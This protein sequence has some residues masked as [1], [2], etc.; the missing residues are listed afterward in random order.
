VV[1]LNCGRVYFDGVEPDARGYPCEDG[2]HLKTVVGIEEALLMGRVVITADHDR[3]ID[4][5]SDD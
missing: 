4:C 2:C 5:D 1:P 3:A